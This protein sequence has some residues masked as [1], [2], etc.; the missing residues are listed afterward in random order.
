MSV[1]SYVA[2]RMLDEV[3]EIAT[4]INPLYEPIFQELYDWLELYTDQYGGRVFFRLP[5]PKQ[6]VSELCNDMVKLYAGI[7]EGAGDEKD[8]FVTVQSLFT[9]SFYMMIKYRDSPSLCSIIPLCF[10]LTSKDLDGWREL[11]ARL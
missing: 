3:C 10:E 8:A 7:F 4:P 6:R 9:V 1:V 5:E 2:R 11:R